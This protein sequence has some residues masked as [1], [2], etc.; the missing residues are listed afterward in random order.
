MTTRR[1]ASGVWWRHARVAWR[2]LRQRGA[3][4]VQDRYR[5]RSVRACPQGDQHATTT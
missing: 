2:G 4:G 1:P 5:P 3:T